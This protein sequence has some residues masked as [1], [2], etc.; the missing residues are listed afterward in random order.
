MTGGA[1]PRRRAVHIS[2]VDQRLIDKGLPPSWEEP[3]VGALEDAQQGGVSSVPGGA[4]GPDSNDARL[5][6][7][8]PPH[9]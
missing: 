4:G 5:Q 6:A 1:R 2:E 3:P 7:E 8:V 9:W